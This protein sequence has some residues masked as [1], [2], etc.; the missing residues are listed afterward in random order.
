M[1]IIH[2]FFFQL[3]VY[4]AKQEALDFEPTADFIG[5]TLPSMSVTTSEIP[6]GSDVI[7]V[8]LYSSI[9]WLLYAISIILFLIWYYHKP[10]SDDKKH[11]KEQ[12]HVWI[13]QNKS[14]VA[15]MVTTA[16]TT[17]VIEACARIANCSVWALNTDNSSG[18][19]L[20]V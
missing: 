1:I 18:V 2:F 20:A 6:I 13:R 14:L 11:K 15:G 5:F 7:M 12:I 3:K 9:L 16:V 17:I 19:F 10:H 8:N 4:T